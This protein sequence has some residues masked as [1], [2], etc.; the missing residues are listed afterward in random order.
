METELSFLLTLLLEH[1]LPKGTKELIKDRI[2][3]IQVPNAQQPARPIMP[4]MV[5]SRPSESGDLANATVSFPAAAP[6]I[7]NRLVGGEVS[8]GPG[9]KGP[10]KW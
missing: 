9:T 3:C 7:P 4:Q 6:V 5:T 2:K 8:T 10:R 1:K